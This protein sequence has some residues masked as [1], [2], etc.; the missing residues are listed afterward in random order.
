MKSCAEC[1]R[2][3]YLIEGRRISLC[4]PCARNFLEPPDSAVPAFPSVWHPMGGGTLL[5]SPPEGLWPTGTTDVTMMVLSTR[6]E[7]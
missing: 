7:L 2:E 1:G 3:D 5:L 4:A 6:G